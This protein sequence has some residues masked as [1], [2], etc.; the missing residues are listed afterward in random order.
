MNH[1]KR[2]PA[3][4]QNFI[5]DTDKTNYWTSVSFVTIWHVRLILYKFQF[6]I[7]KLRWIDLRIGHGI[8]VLF[9][10]GRGYFLVIYNSKFTVQ[11]A[12]LQVVYRL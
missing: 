9:P 1:K 5:L 4:W 8:M 11:T 2:P 10:R 7:H 12:V 3:H 6:L